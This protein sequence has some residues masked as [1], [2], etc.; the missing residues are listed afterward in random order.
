M[1]NTSLCGVRADITMQ[2]AA[3]ESTLARQALQPRQGT[4]PHPSN[5]GQNPANAASPVERRAVTAHAQRHTVTCRALRAV[6]EGV[7]QHVLCCVIVAPAAQQPVPNTLAL[8]GQARHSCQHAAYLIDIAIVVIGLVVECVGV[9]VRQR[10][11]L[12]LRAANMVVR[13]PLAAARPCAAF[14]TP[15]S[16]CC[17]T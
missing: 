14:T 1:A 17:S 2:H 3:Q 11:V 16:R 10:I 8:N 15:L 7:L 13:A 4:P 12:N 9:P 5:G 6:E